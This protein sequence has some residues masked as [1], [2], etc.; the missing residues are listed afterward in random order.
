MM[1]RHNSR[2][3]PV[4]VVLCLASLAI[5]VVFQIELDQ[6]EFD[7]EILTA[8]IAALVV[9]NQVFSRSQ[10]MHLNYRPASLLLVSPPP[11]NP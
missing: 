4:L 5:G 3:S 11:K 8:A 10:S 9:A 1:K 2:I 7:E 6:T